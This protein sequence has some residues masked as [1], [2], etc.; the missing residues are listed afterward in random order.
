MYTLDHSNFRIIRNSDSKAI[1]KD[2]HDLDYLTYLQWEH[3]QYGMEMSME[4]AISSMN[5]ICKLL[6]IATDFTQSIDAPYNA[7]QKLAW[8]EYRQSLR[9]MSSNTSDARV[10]VWPTMPGNV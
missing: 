6:L 7:E 2:S 8:R 9:E 10:P 3:D 5:R 1:L 4:Q